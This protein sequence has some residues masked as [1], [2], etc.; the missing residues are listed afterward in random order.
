[1]LCSYFYSARWLLRP[2][3]NWHQQCIVLA[4]VQM[5]VEARARQELEEMLIRIEKHF[6]VSEGGASCLLFG[7]VSCRHDAMGCR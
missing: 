4:V 1:M 2:K 7:L 5:R 6:F 3:P